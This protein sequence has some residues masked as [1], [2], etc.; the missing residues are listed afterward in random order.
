MQSVS[1]VMRTPALLNT[2]LCRPCVWAS[3]HLALSLVMSRWLLELQ[4]T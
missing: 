2:V 3:C 1:D 4:Q